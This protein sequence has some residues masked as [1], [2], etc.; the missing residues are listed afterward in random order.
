MI[1]AATIVLAAALTA[2]G[3]PPVAA[4]PPPGPATA[5][6]AA[7][8]SPPAGTGTLLAYGAIGSAAGAARGGRGYGGA[9]AFDRRTGDDLGALR[10]GLEAGAY[11]GALSI[12]LVYSPLR[13]LFRPYAAA[14]AGLGYFAGD[15]GVPA[16]AALGLEVALPAHLSLA[17]EGRAWWVSAYDER[18][19]DSTRWFGAVSVL[20]GVGARF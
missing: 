12:G 11:G 20:A 10:L 15:V 18:T 14:M 8:A 16:G 5:Q 7:R 1:H 9:L 2:A 13:G 19:A 17:L 3:D 4:L 6:P